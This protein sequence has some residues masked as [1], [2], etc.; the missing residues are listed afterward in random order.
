MELLIYA[1]A[2]QTEEL[3]AEKIR[4]MQYITESV[5]YLERILRAKLSVGEQSAF[6]G[7]ES[8]KSKSPNPN[9]A[10]SVSSNEKIKVIKQAPIRIGQSQSQPAPTPT[11]ISESSEDSER[12]SDLS[13]S[14]L[15]VSSI[16]DDHEAHEQLQHIDTFHDA[17]LTHFLHIMRG[18][19]TPWKVFVFGSESWGTSCLA[20]DIDVA[21]SLHFRHSRW[22]K[23]YLL[24]HLSALLTANDRERV[25]QITTILNAKCPII[26]IQHHAL[27]A[28]SVDISIADCFCLKR[29]TL[30]IS[31]I[32]HY[33]AR[34]KLPV[35]KL[36]IFIK[37]WSKNRGINDS[38]GGYLNSFGFALL[39]VKFL[40]CTHGRDIPRN[41]HILSYN[42]A[43]TLR[44]LLFEFFVFFLFDFDLETRAVA[45][46]AESAEVCARWRTEQRGE[47]VLE[48]VDPANGRN[49]VGAQVEH[50]QW[51]HIKSEFVRSFLI[52]RKE[53]LA[54]SDEDGAKKMSAMAL[55]RV[56]TAIPSYH[57]VL[58]E[59]QMSR[60]DLDSLE[61]WDELEEL[62][63]AEQGECEDDLLYIC[64]PFEH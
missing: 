17:D 45:V 8:A 35:R 62:Q 4:L 23:K 40:Q 49:N 56:L 11:I 55:F 1:Q 18:H 42:N 36:M 27:V 31:L 64:Q 51:L 44:A 52:L 6:S 7:C 41:R 38:F 9:E 21:I 48:I 46:T 33:E 20:S 54:D 47:S 53:E 2:H 13:H 57:H 26:R 43:K 12:D 34:L 25:L 60:S 19:T 22:V 10:S 32:E 63:Q 28:V 3:R 59:D 14:L 39:I 5:Q 16:S 37:I 58:D 15:T 24:Q 30:M 50:E 29:K 61:S